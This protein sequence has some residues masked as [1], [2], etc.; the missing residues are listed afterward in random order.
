MRRAR[1]TGIIVGLVVVLLNIG[2]V[3]GIVVGLE[4]TPTTRDSSSSSSSIDP[5]PT[6]SGT[7]SEQS[8]PSPR[9]VLAR[10]QEPSVVV[11]GSDEG[12]GET[13]WVDRLGSVVVDRGRTVEYARLSPDDPTKYAGAVR[14]GD[15]RRLGLRNASVSGSSLSYAKNRSAFLVPKDADVVL[16]SYQPARTKGLSGQ[17]SALVRAVESQAPKAVVA[18]VVGPDQGTPSYAQVRAAQRRWASRQGIPSVDIGKAFD[19]AQGALLLDPASQSGLT[20]TGADVWAQA[21]ADFLLG[22]VAASP[23]PASSLTPE[24]TE[25]DPISSSITTPPPTSEPVTTD[26]PPPVVTSTPAPTVPA[27]VYPGPV[28]P[29]PVDPGPVDPTTDPQ[30][31]STGSD[32]TSTSSDGGEPSSSSDAEE[33]SSTDESPTSL[34]EST[35]DISDTATM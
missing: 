5:A 20:S 33:S 2:I 12:V 8:M 24:A 11:L 15:G 23:P 35:A 17:L 31:S 1:L 18:L 32:P 7:Q 22:R 19:S 29:G 25:S 14:S 34:S 26:A 10:R 13:G 9:E 28:D 30:P 6:T 4:G 21:V 3:V 27:P 16:I